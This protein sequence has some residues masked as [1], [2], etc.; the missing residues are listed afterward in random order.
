MV[1]KASEEP[2]GQRASAVLSNGTKIDRWID[3]YPKE[4]DVLWV[5]Q[6]INKAE[7]SK[8]DNNSIVSFPTRS[9]LIVTV[10]PAVQARSAP[11]AVLEHETAKDKLQRRT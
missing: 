3:R 1:A 7:V 11:T 4:D 2:T 10:R 6:T 8:L 5:F 9:L